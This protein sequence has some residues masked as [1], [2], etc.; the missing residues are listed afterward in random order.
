MRNTGGGV[1]QS[2]QGTKKYRQIIRKLAVDFKIA[3]SSE[4]ALAGLPGVWLKKKMPAN[5][6]V[7]NYVAS[8]W[9]TILGFVQLAHWPQKNSP[10][11]GHWFF[12]LWVRP[13]LRGLG[14]G[15]SL[16]LKVIE[17]TKDSGNKELFCL[18]RENNQAALNLY[19]KLGFEEAK[20]QFFEELLQQE[21]LIQ[22]TRS[23]LILS[24]RLS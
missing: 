21:E 23:F 2:L 8:K 1:I 9:R 17:A 24:K 12:G 4:Q 11:V 6:D 14:I 3:E 7:T 20:V 18:V 10:Y 13:I 15:E 22:G 5:P 16:M 19:Y